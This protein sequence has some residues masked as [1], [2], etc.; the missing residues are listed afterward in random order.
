MIVSDWLKAHPRHPMTVSAGTSIEEALDRMLEEPC[1]RDIY[2]VD[3]NKRLIGH[4]SHTRL[5]ECLLIE[6]RPVHT[7]RQLMDRV[8]GGNVAAHM[9]PELYFANCDEP[10][11]EVISR[12]LSKQLEDMPIIDNTG[13]ILGAIN[14]SDILREWRRDETAFTK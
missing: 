8:A 2:I 11:D 4:L 1:V 12:Q 9:D 6:H 7:R 10:L 14:I 13:K 3:G 5:A